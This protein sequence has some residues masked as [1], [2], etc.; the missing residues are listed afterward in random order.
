M[1]R[2]RSNLRGLVRLRTV[3]ERD[4]RIGLATALTEHRQAAAKVADLEQL[5]VTLP[6]PAST[7]LAAFHGRQHTLE[8][9][10]T[11]LTTAR[12]ELETTEQVSSAAR[13]RWVSDRSRLAAVESLVERRMTALRVERERRDVR[14]L[15]EVAEQMWRRNQAD[16][17]AIADGG[18]A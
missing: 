9:I 3:R 8:L 11:A 17:V 15:D 4:S 16:L 18:A 5:L 13:D 14:R 6:P 10:R 1:S 7:D 2:P 12:E